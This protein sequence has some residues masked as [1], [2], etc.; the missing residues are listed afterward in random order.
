MNKDK[1]TIP[2]VEIERKPAN[3][4]DSTAEL[5]SLLPSA[6]QDAIIDLIK[7]ILLENNEF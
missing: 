6:A 1:I 7:S 5:F 3:D 2:E 4:V